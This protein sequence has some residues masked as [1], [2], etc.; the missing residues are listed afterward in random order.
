MTAHVNIEFTRDFTRDIEW[1]FAF[2]SKSPPFAFARFADGEAA[3]LRGE[4]HKAKSDGWETSGGGVPQLVDGLRNALDCELPGW[5]VGITAASH[6]AADHAYLMGQ[7]AVDPKRITFAELFIFGNLELFKTLIEPLDYCVVGHGAASLGERG[8]DIPPDATADPEFDIEP[9]LDWMLKQTRPI[10]LAAGPV[11]KW[12]AFE[13][14]WTTHHLHEYQRNSVIDVGSALSP[15]LRGR[16]TR[17]YH[18]SKNDVSRAVL[19]W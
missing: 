9:P 14:W 6:H 3:L 12:L 7:V 11:A 17:R 19:Q 2:L 1:L 13:Y 18:D 10:F 15:T 8:Y 4:S 5:H 16:K